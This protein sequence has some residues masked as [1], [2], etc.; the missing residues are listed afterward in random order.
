VPEE[1]GA[2]FAV[3][4][5]TKKAIESKFEQHVAP[6]MFKKIAIVATTFMGLVIPA[7][8]SITKHG[9]EKGA[10]TKPT[11]AAIAFL[12]ICC[13]IL[14]IIAGITLHEYLIFKRVIHHIKEGKWVRTEDGVCNAVDLSM[15]EPV[16]LVSGKTNK[17]TL[18]EFH[19]DANFL[20]DLPR[21]YWP[22]TLIKSHGKNIVVAQDAA[23]QTQVSFSVK[24]QKQ[25]KGDN[26]C[27]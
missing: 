11:I 26:A 27:D 9:A 1:K 7:T 8:I 3:D 21:L 23:D 10:I 15:E 22:F 13:I 19:A 14:V 25:V 6:K 12:L 24:T 16:F 18:F 4:E 20:A 17:G 2:S 5:K